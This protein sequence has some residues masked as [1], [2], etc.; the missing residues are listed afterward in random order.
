LLAPSVST[1][2]FSDCCMVQEVADRHGLG[3]HIH[4]HESSGEVTDW[5]A[6][7]G[8]ETPIGTMDRLGMLKEGLVAVHMTQLTP[9]ELDRIAA[10]KVSPNRPSPSADWP[11]APAAAHAAAARRNRPP[12]R[13]AGRRASAARAAARAALRGSRPDARRAMEPRAAGEPPRAYPAAG[14]ASFAHSWSPT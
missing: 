1:P 10:S 13:A 11:T 3:M 5:K 4:V 14:Q 12:L 7:Q 8:G 9:A 2:G 6:A